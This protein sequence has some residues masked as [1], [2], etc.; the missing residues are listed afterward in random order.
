MT[1]ERE[2][3]NVLSKVFPNDFWEDAEQLSRGSRLTEISQD[4]FKRIFLK[5]FRLLK[6]P[7]VSTHYRAHQI[8]LN[9]SMTDLSDDL[10]MS[11]FLSDE[12]KAY[13]DSFHISSAELSI[14][15]IKICHK[16]V[17]VERESSIDR[18][19][20]TLNCLN[21]SIDTLKHLSE[22]SIF[23]E[24]DQTVIKIKI[25]QLICQCFSSLVKSDCKNV[26]SHLK[27]VFTLL[28]LSVSE[29]EITCGLIMC[30]ITTIGN[31]YIRKSPQKVESSEQLKLCSHLVIKQME[32]IS[33]D[34]DNFLFIVQKRLMEIVNA[35]KKQEAPQQ[36]RKRKRARKL[37]IKDHHHS[38][39]DTCI[40]ERILIDS[41]PFV[42]CYRHL[43]TIL[44]HLSTG[45][46]CCNGDIKTIEIFLRSTT[47]APRYLH[48]IEEKIIRVL[49]EKSKI[50]IYCN[51]K[52]S[53]EEFTCDYFRLLRSEMARREGYELY[54][55]L[56]HMCIIQKLMTK[57]FL[58][59]FI[60]EVIVTIFEEEKEKYLSNTDA[61]QESR[62]KAAICL[63]IITE[64]CNDSDFLKKFLTPERTNHLRDCSLIP[65]VSMSSCVILS[66]G[67]KLLEDQ[68]I[69]NQIKSIFFANILYLIHELIAI[70][71][72]IDLPRDLPLSR[73]DSGI[74]SSKLTANST[75]DASDFEVLDQQTVVVKENLSNLDILLLNMVH[76]NILSELIVKY[77]LFQAEF[78]ANIHNNFHKNILFTIAYHALHAML[79]RKETSFTKIA[80]KNNQ[81]SAD[82]N[83]SQ[84]VN[85]NL[86][87]NTHVSII[88]QNYDLNYDHIMR[89]YNLFE[90]S[91]LFRDKLQNDYQEHSSCMLY[92][93]RRDN[94]KFI[95]LATHRDD[96]LPDSLPD[97]LKQQ[98]RESSLQ[99]Q[100]WINTFGTLF[101]S[102]GIREA[103]SRV[104]NR[105]LKADEELK[106]IHRL[107]TIKEITEK[108]GLK[109]LSVIARNCFD[110]SFRLTSSP[111]SMSEYGANIF[112]ICLAVRILK[113]A[114]NISKSD[115]NIFL[116][117]YIYFHPS[118]TD[119]PVISYQIT[120]SYIAEIFS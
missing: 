85:E 88:C 99:Y 15:I 20:L 41:F 23:N 78:I 86:L 25:T 7:S 27:K 104:L 96:F 51:E 118:N 84:H 58:T 83:L 31:L 82:V 43:K 24:L 94:V 46:C 2:L 44:S 102:K 30:I 60:F 12:F 73:H 87:K 69:L 37:D 48:F 79:M 111:H 14:G 32:I 5:E 35:L 114:G 80:A 50:C 110:I 63:R 55:F 112:K 64:N 45:I 22:R 70:Y 47:I 103:I 8:S 57:E 67:L 101:E 6:Q 59:E 76:W 90:I 18:N 113:S 49:F 33:A 116:N 109:Y 77:P 97:S 29:K 42:K 56:N 119:H 17:E 61:Y 91:H 54:A 65:T 106:V 36:T 13:S 3:V 105:F 38:Q 66:N 34:N 40:F 16:L 98:T 26:K 53:S 74:S 19:F 81:D 28:E 108:F 117:T 107:N 21:F 100:H 95:N 92:R 120:L 4:D 93:M 11:K 9:S 72:Q 1:N 115:H 75:G 39:L 10:D 52:L 68:T 89:A 62:L 71:D